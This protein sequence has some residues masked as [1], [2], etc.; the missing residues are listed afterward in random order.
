MEEIEIIVMALFLGVGAA[1]SPGPILALMVSETLKYGKKEGFAVTLSPLITDIPIFL[2]SYLLLYRG[3]FYID[4][5]PKF[6]YVV[7]GVLLIYIGYKN[8]R[9]RYRTMEYSNTK[10]GFFYSFFKGLTV[11]LFNPYTYGFWFFIAINFFSEEFFKTL[12]FFLSFFVAFLI[13]QLYIIIL[14]SKTRK[15]LKE[16]LYTTIIKLVGFV[17]IFLGVS[18]LTSAIK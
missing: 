18:F 8:V 10:R 1:I 12:L 5:I 2:I 17:F 6:F 13:T 7:G 16:K 9:Y 14:I 4:N 11:N 3:I 15:F